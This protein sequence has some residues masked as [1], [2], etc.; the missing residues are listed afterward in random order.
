MNRPNGM[1]K[2]VK[3]WLLGSRNIGGS[4]LFKTSRTV[5]ILAS[6]TA[7]LATA[8]A[9]SVT[10]NIH[11]PHICWGAK[12][13]CTCVFYHCSFFGVTTIGADHLVA[14]F[15]GVTIFCDIRSS[16]SNSYFNLSWSANGMDH[17]VLMQNGLASVTRGRCG[18]LLLPSI[19]FDC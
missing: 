12:G 16:R 9:G 4:Y 1:I 5:K 15:T 7:K 2:V 8:W 11:V 13:L 19:S 6:L 10:D 18:N 17:R 3:G 14:S